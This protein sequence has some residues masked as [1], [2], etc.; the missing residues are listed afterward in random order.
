MRIDFRIRYEERELELDEHLELVGQHFLPVDLERL[1]DAL[2]EFCEFLV[3]DVVEFG[4]QDE[5]GTCNALSLW[6][7]EV[8]LE[9]D[10]LKEHVSLSNVPEIKSTLG[11]RNLFHVP[12][13]AP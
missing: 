8:T 3:L 4:R 11:V 6:F 5:A 1:L 2:Y 13:E 7:R 12:F 9:N 10:L